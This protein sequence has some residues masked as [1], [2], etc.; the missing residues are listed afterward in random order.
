MSIQS[1]TVGQKLLVQSGTVEDDYIKD[2]GKWTLN[3][4]IGN[5]SFNS[6]VEFPSVYNSQPQVVVGIIGF[7]IGNNANSRLDVTAKNVTVAGF[8]IEFST[9]ADSTI[10][11]ASVSWIAIG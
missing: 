6:F 1:S 3:Q 11:G 7:D 10:F 5:R 9:R 2:Q 8:E 4:G